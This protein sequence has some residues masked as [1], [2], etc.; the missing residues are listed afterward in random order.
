MF[1]PGSTGLFGKMPGIKLSSSLA[2]IDQ[3]LLN[4]MIFLAVISQCMRPA[5]VSAASAAQI[6]VMVYLRANQNVFL[7]RS[8]V[9]ICKIE[10]STFAM[11][12]RLMMIIGEP[13]QLQP[14]QQQ[15]PN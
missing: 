14:K 15:Q 2:F 11:F 12:K 9:C 5:A 1:L 13:N 6:V 7:S 8:P 4:N 10:R 3:L